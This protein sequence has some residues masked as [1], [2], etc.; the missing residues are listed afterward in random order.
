MPT[1]SARRPCPEQRVLVLVGFNGSP[2]GDRA[3]AYAAGHAART[4]ADLLLLAA[5]EDP[6]LWPTHVR[7]RDQRVQALLRQAEAVLAGLDVRW[8]MQISD[9]APSAALRDCAR[10][11]HADLIV[12]GASTARWRRLLSHRVGAALARDAPAPILVVP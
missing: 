2:R 3:L 7:R 9:A 8:R 5:D 10:R 6:A 12:V 4:G 11:C 1:T